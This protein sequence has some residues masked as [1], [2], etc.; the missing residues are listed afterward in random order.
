M[1]PVLG[2]RSMYFGIWGGGEGQ[3]G[4]TGK[5][6]RVHTMKAYMGFS[7]IAPLILYLGNGWR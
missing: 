5:D 1:L 7:G 4:R 3:G 6:V 2:K